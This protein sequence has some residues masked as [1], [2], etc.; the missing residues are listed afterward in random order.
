MYDADSRDVTTSNN[1]HLRQP[2][3]KPRKA[4]ART[5]VPHDA[6]TSKMTTRS[7]KYAHNGYNE[8][9]ASYMGDK[10]GT[11]PVRMWY[12]PIRM[13]ICLYQIMQ[14]KYKITMGFLQSREFQWNLLRTT[15]LIEQELVTM[16][17]P[18][19]FPSSK[20]MP[21]KTDEEQ[22]WL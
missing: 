13:H 15:V 14:F 17:G 7:Q 12:Y 5:V 10:F 6:G 20:P 2:L 8:S 21:T 11:T 22:R 19:S 18:R 3:L 1:L 9:H 4:T 16:M